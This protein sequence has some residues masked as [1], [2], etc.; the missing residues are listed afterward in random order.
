MFSSSPSG[1]PLHVHYACCSVVL[2][3]SNHGE[4]CLPFFFF[5]IV[6]GGSIVLGD[7]RGALASTI[8]WGI[9]CAELLAGFFPQ[10]RLQQRSESRG[11]GS[12][13]RTPLTRHRPLEPET[14]LRM[15]LAGTRGR[16]PTLRGWRSVR[17]SLMQH[18]ASWWAWGRRFRRKPRVPA[19]PSTCPP[20]NSPV[21]VYSARLTR[22]REAFGRSRKQH[23]HAALQWA[24]KRHARLKIAKHWERQDRH[25]HIPN[26]LCAGR[27]ALASTEIFRSARAASNCLWCAHSSVYTALTSPMTSAV[28]SIWQ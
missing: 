16:M 21:S 18:P 6:Q 7:G 28:I 9:C 2:R 15:A 12:S 3:P 1:Q 5:Q 26:R 20:Q 4:T 27:G 14:R 11:E 13:I 8:W 24:T 23:R 22:I 17:L 25:V 10:I 19:T